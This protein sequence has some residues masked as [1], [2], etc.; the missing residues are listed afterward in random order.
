M[1]N[2]LIGPSTQTWGQQSPLNLRQ[3]GPTSLAKTLTLTL[4]SLRSRGG[5]TTT[6]SA[7]VQP[8]ENPKL[9]RRVQDMLA[10]QNFNALGNPGVPNRGLP[11]TDRQRFCRFTFGGN[12]GLKIRQGPVP[13]LQADT[14]V[15]HTAHR[16]KLMRRGQSQSVQWDGC[17]RYPTAR[18]TCYPTVDLNYILPCTLTCTGTYPTTYPFYPAVLIVLGTE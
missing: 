6:P 18:L 7:V 13:G 3:D 9:V 10:S 4:E 14:T 2:K 1:L 17:I 12:P 5:V 16:E 8:P 11:S 15:P